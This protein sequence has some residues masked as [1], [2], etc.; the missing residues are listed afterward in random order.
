VLQKE[1]HTIDWH[2][3]LTESGQALA[4][5]QQQLQLA[6]ALSAPEPAAAAWQL[7]LTVDSTCYFLTEGGTAE[8]LEQQQHEVLAGVTSK[9]T[10]QQQLRASPLGLKQQI[11]KLL[12]WAGELLPLL[13]LTVE[14]LEQMIWEV[15]QVCCRMK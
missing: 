4:E 5:A 12:R 7:N 10:Q 1:D 15:W 13:P 6:T 14:E 2:Q 9:Q 8:P 3:L 11:P